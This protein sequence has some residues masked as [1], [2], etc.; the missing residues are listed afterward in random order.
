MKIAYFDC[1]TGVAGDMCLGALVSAGVPLDY[2]RSQLSRL[3]IDPEFQL[4]AESVLRNGFAATKLY[5]E[6]A[7]D[8]EPDRIRAEE[9]PSEPPP[10]HSHPH[11]HSHS[12]SHPHPH[13]APPLPTSSPSRTWPQIAQ[14]IQQADLPQ[15]VRDWSLAAFQTLAISEATVHGVDVESVHFHEVGATDAIVDIVGTCLGLD[16][17]GVDV[18]HCSALP[19]GGGTVMTDHGRLPV[20]TPAVLEIW[21]RYPVPVYSNDIQRELVTPTGAALMA[22]LA[23][24]FGSA[25][26]LQI[27]AL[28]L[29]AGNRNFSI[30]N[31]LRLWVGEA[32]TASNGFTDVAMPAGQSMTI[33]PQETIAVLETQIDDLSPQAIAYALELLLEAGA[34]DVFTQAVG[35]KKSRPG[36]LLTVLCRP[37]LISTC[38]QIIFQETSTLGIRRTLQTRTVLNRMIQTVKTPYGPVRLKIASPDS[39]T[40]HP[41]QVQPEYEDCAQLARQ[42]QVAWREI[43]RLALQAWTNR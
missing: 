16:W 3:G 38:E 5:V 40:D 15:R 29:G 24:H 37:E 7:G 36:Q 42:H 31:V 8:P 23:T 25:P 17:L 34:L 9:I 22:T 21:R 14:L 1:P 43:H 39:G 11:P 30:P 4:R 32:T 12:H 20:P 27:K 10:P 35:M 18:I 19:T 13:P 41:T 6:I 33:A 2:L 26:S 28:G